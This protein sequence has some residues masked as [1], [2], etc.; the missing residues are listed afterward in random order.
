LMELRPIRAVA[1]A[2][3]PSHTRV[4]LRRGLMTTAWWLAAVLSRSE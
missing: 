1:H 4:R 3:V 2:D